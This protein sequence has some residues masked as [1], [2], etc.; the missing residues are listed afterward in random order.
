LN[1]FLFT[2]MRARAIGSFTQAFPDFDHGF[3]SRALPLPYVCAVIA[4]NRADDF[5]AYLDRTGISYRRIA[6]AALAEGNIGSSDTI[7]LLD[8]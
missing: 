7:T 5:A 3:T 8:G 6:E 4:R 2:E 1:V